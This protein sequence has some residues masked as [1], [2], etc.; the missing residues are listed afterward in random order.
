[1]NEFKILSPGK[2]EIMIVPALPAELNGHRLAGA[3]AMIAKGL[4]GR[5]IFQHFAG[6]GFDIWFSNYQIKHPIKF[7]GGSD[8]PLLEFHTQYTNNFKAHWKGPLDSNQYSKQY[9]LTFMREVETLG[10]FPSVKPCDTFDIHFH[11]KILQPYAKYCPRLDKFLENVEN[12]KSTNLLEVVRFL[13][14]GMEEA[15]HAMINYSMY[16][17]LAGQF[18]KGRVHEL[19]VH[20]VYHIGQIDKLPAIDPVEIKKAEE[21]YKL[22]LSNFSIYDSVEEL[23]AK[24]GTK[25]H[26]LQ[27]AFKYRYGTTVAKFSREERLKK[28]HEILMTENDI[29]LAV[30]LAVGYNDTG[31]FSTAF[32][33]YFKYSP[34]HI[35]KRI[36]K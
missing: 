15:I 11:K 31:N 33:S 36:K 4:F 20:M 21:A 26:K 1:M 32:K 22:I 5:M 30:A 35:Q 17:G 9:Q 12:R 10:E 29:L 28:A 25:E 27:M 16:D 6:E 14:R 19:L 18:F 34:G 8:D 24:V 13:S 2:E 3:E 23:A 7:Y